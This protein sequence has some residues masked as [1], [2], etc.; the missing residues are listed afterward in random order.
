MAVAVSAAAVTAFA[1]APA[2]LAQSWPAKPVRIIV[3][4]P[5]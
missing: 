1:A 2:A 5:Y 4:Q 3:T